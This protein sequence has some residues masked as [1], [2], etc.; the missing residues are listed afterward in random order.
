M[1]ALMTQL[2]KTKLIKVIFTPNA[3]RDFEQMK[4]CVAQERNLFYFTREERLYLMT[5]ASGQAI[6]SALL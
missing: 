2:L 6:R 4:N 1:T 3:E 5:D